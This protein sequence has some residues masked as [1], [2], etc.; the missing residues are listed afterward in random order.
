MVYIAGFA[1]IA[2]YLSLLSHSEKPQGADSYRFVRDNAPALS[3]STWLMQRICYW[4]YRR[5]IITFLYTAVTGMVHQNRRS[6]LVPKPRGPFTL[7]MS[8]ARHNT[9][10]GV[11]V[12]IPTHYNERYY[13]YVC[14][15]PA[16]PP[17]H[18]M[19]LAFVRILFDY[20]SL[21][22]LILQC[23]YQIESLSDIQELV[24]LMYL[25]QSQLDLNS[26]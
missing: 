4:S 17:S 15:G 7:F 18:K 16:S 20:S 11:F 23:D 12:R 26:L 3:S 24:L 22:I 8:N 1:R 21:L 6:F 14:T 25:V 19:T 2:L 5:L 9:I 13:N 10:E